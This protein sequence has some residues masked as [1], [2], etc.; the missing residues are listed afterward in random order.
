MQSR[1][2]ISVLPLCEKPPIFFFSH[3]TTQIHQIVQVNSAEIGNVTEIG[4]PLYTE[5]KFVCL[6]ETKKFTAEIITTAKI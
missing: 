1:V 4:E 3:K 2:L 6:T 5:Q